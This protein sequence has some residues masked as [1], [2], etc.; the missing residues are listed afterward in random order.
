MPVGRPQCI[1]PSR[2]DDA[3]SGTPCVIGILFPNTE[4]QRFDR[5]VQR[6]RVLEGVSK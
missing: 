6:F 5:A 4:T 3:G 1:R 2:T